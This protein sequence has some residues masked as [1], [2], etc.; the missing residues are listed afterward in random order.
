MAVSNSMGVRFSLQGVEETLQQI[1]ELVA[2]MPEDPP[3]PFQQFIQRTQ[4][5]AP[6]AVFHKAGFNPNELRDK[7]GHW[8]A[9][10]APTTS[11]EVVDLL[12]QH[13]LPHVAAVE[14]MTGPSPRSAQS[15][16]SKLRQA[17]P[18]FAAMFVNHHLHQ[19]D[20][21]LAKIP[22]PVVVGTG[23]LAGAV[24]PGAP[25]A[26]PAPLPTAPVPPPV[27]PPAP[28]PTPTV[29]PGAGTPLGWQGNRAT[30]QT[31]PNKEWEIHPNPDPAQGGFVVT[32]GGQ[33]LIRPATGV[34][35]AAATARNAQFIAGQMERSGQLLQQHYSLGPVLAAQNAAPAPAIPV[36]PPFS[37][38]G[39]PMLP[40]QQTPRGGLEAPSA[41][42]GATWGIVKMANF[43]L[44]GV[45]VRSPNGSNNT[46]YNLKDRAGN[47]ERFPTSAAAV[48]AAEAHEAGDRTYLLDLSKD[49]LQAAGTNPSAAPALVTPSG[50]NASGNPALDW[51]A[52]PGG[53]Q[54]KSK[55]P[56]VTWE[57]AQGNFGWVAAART[58]SGA[59]YSLQDRNQKVQIFGTAAAA[60][61]AAEDY[62][63][64]DRTHLLNSAVPFAAPATAP[65][66]VPPAAVPTT[67][68]AHPDLQGRLLSWNSQG[69][70]G[71]V[72]TATGPSGIPYSLQMRPDG[73]VDLHLGGATRLYSSVQM[74]AA[75]ADKHEQAFV[76]G[77]GAPPL[78]PTPPP[79]TKAFAPTEARDP[80][81]RW[82]AQGGMDA[83]GSTAER[84][85]PYSPLGERIIWPP[86]LSDLRILGPVA[87]PGGIAGQG[88]L[89]PTKLQDASGKVWVRK[90]AP[91]MN[92]VTASE[93]DANLVYHQVGVPALPVREYTE[94]GVVYQ[95]APWMAGG[96]DLLA[97]AKPGTK[98]LEYF[99]RGFAT[100][101]LLGAWDV[102]KNANTLLFNGQVPV[103]M[104]NGGAL[105]YSATGKIKNDY[106]GADSWSPYPDELWTLRNPKVAKGREWVFAELAAEDIVR[107]MRR[108][109]DR[110]SAIAAVV[111]DPKDRE[112]VQKR[113]QAMDL[114]IQF[115]DHSG[116]QGPD[117]DRTLFQELR[118]MKAAQVLG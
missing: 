107:Q 113:I 15:A 88:G 89:D 26:A 79:V 10:A 101:A 20:P 65:P 102:V 4:R 61:A 84:G 11:D 37:A 52:T 80:Q 117:L 56:G 19:I 3:T 16:R 111:R 72:H 118:R 12:Y 53:M 60:A 83:D 106:R 29:A 24:P 86:K 31:F 57:L 104:D 28:P 59:A 1:R 75:D 43:F 41:V 109:V 38:A 23:A 110:G 2:V 55:L 25:V 68:V 114:L 50:L 5:S 33:L 115:A 40:W 48:A 58:P 100:D 9:G 69:P 36:P 95:L 47:I 42:P 46:S 8:V 97:V 98:P 70:L 112:M 39:P 82:T 96:Q 17:D 49:P 34:P 7:A 85:T 21:K 30:S 103:R 63:A 44:A 6:P 77:F 66:V 90:G 73:K 64:G 93:V 91:G 105:S 87:G 74:A 54:A 116:L 94:G 67:A 62:D 71:L 45:S 14:Q 51:Q 76:H 35:V 99:S 32:L 108:I 13:H 27:A 92:A 22:L 81:G 78:A 18:T